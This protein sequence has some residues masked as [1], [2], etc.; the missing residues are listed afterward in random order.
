MTISPQRLI[1]TWVETSGVKGKAVLGQAGLGYALCPA[2]PEF[3]PGPRCW[4]WMQGG[5]CC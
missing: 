1:I 2:R 3:A 5:L 4:G